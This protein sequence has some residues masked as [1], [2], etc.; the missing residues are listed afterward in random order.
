MRLRKFRRRLYLGL[1]SV[2]ALQRAGNLFPR[3]FFDNADG[4]LRF[5][6]SVANHGEIV[7]GGKSEAQH[8]VE[9]VFIQN[10]AHI[11][12][13]RHDEPLEPQLFTQQFRHDSMT[14]RGRRFLGLETGIPAVTNHHAIDD[15]FGAHC[16]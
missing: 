7:A 6:D 12:V 10:R 4:L 2:N 8:F 9:T 5:V 14:E 15:L 13:V 3:Q 16:L 1:E 11:E